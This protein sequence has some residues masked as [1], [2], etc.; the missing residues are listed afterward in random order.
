VGLFDGA[1]TQVAAAIRAELAPLVAELGA[2]RAE[3]AQLRQAVQ[4]N[5]AAQPKARPRPTA[6]R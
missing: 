2:L 3:V 4:Q 1:A 5:T 6:P